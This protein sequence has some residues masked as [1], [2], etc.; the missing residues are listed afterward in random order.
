MKKLSFTL[1]SESST[2]VFC[3]PQD[4]LARDR[5]EA[6]YVTDTSIYNLHSRHFPG[7]AAGAPQHAVEV[8]SPGEK[9]KDWPNVE[10]ILNA[11]FALGMAR[12][13]QFIGVGGGVITDLTGFAA[14]IFMRGCDLVL[15]PTTLLAMVDAAFGGKTGINFAGL[16]NM[17]GSF[18]P[19]REV[20]ISTEFVR[21]LSEREYYSGLAEVIKSAALDDSNLLD[22]LEGHVADIRNRKDSV[23]QELVFRSIGVK[24]RIVEADLREQGIRAH[25]NLGHT[26]A[27]ALESVAGFGAWSHG[28]AVAWGILRALD[29][30]VR[31]GITPEAYAT[32]IA[33]LISTYGFRTLAEADTDALLNAMRQ[34][35]KKKDGKLRFIVQAGLCD[36]RIVE[37]EDA[38]VR[39]VLDSPRLV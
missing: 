7:P 1:G 10:R 29:L 3:S 39:E 11:A 6:V 38:I 25:L 34:D 31:L 21:T 5:R 32:R 23:L 35:K 14:S 17:V 13:G 37:A 19:A 12:D 9:S 27:H 8:L 4:A 18:L 30:G 24:G 15:V 26:F 28:E 33:K 22:I 2:V 36:T 16:K 20:R